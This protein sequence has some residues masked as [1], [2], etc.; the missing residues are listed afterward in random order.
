MMPILLFSLLKVH[1][2]T[3]IYLINYCTLTAVLQIFLERSKGE[4]WTPPQLSD[5][6]C[7]YV[8]TS[9]VFV[10]PM[11]LQLHSL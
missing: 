5:K 10:S 6:L 1:P 4:V 8:C 9:V 11:A 7:T 2:K 3:K